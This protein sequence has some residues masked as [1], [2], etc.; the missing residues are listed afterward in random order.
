MINLRFCIAF[1][2]TMKAD[3]IAFENRAQLEPMDENGCSLSEFAFEMEL[4]NAMIYDFENNW[5]GI[6]AHLHYFVSQVWL[7]DY[8]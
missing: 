2:S 8:F 3:A 7:C 6:A 5:T 1:V 4:E